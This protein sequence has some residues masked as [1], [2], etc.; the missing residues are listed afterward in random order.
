MHKTRPDEDRFWE[1]AEPI[2]LAGCWVWT[3]T[4]SNNG[5]GTFRIGSLTDG[6]R[7]N[8][9]AHRYAAELCYGAIPAG[10]QALHHCDNKLCVNPEHLYVGSHSD[11][12]RDA[13]KRGRTGGVSLPGEKNP[14]AKLSAQQV[15]RIRASEKSQ[16]ELAQE[17]GV[18]STQISWIKSGR[19]WA[20]L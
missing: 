5:Y 12:M 8:I 9:S 11:N 18:S 17:F 1:K 7:R 3:G 20:S 6:T 16:S 13:V 10:M 19:S 15:L 2:P 14:N 4:L